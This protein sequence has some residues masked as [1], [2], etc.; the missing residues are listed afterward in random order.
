M[1]QEELNKPQGMIISCE[2]DLF[3]RISRSISEI[4]AG[5]LKHKTF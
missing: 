5:I 1:V 2:T 3:R 4:F